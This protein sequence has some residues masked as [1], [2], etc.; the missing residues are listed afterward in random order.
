M[1]KL[2]KE[3][4]DRCVQRKGEHFVLNFQMKQLVTIRNLGDFVK[5]DKVRELNVSQNN[6]KAMESILII[7]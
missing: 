7:M 2:H 6:L 4:F 3:L 5:V 1:I